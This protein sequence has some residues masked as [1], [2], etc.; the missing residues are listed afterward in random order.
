MEPKIF[1]PS[2][3]REQ[4]FK[5]TTVNIDGKRFENCKFL[6]CTI[7][8]SGFA[9]S[10]ASSCYFSPD[11]K[12]GLAGVAGEVLQT[13]KGFGWHFGYGD[14]PTADSVT[15]IPTPKVPS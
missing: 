7:M 2:I 15:E 10:Q 12:W 5:N 4:E 1:T 14:A 6:N 13:L 9:P 11:T 8:F 3:V